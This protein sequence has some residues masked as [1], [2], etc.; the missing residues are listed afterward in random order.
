M[1]G[2]LACELPAR[3]APG[4]AHHRAAPEPIGPKRWR[5]SPLAID[6][7]KPRRDERGPGHRA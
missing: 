5:A 4:A 2:R 6:T 7:L 3:Q 1:P